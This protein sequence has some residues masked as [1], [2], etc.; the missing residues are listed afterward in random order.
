MDRKKLLKL[1]RQDE[2]GKLD[3]KE[4]LHLKTSSDKKEFVKDVCAL[5]NSSG[6]RAYLVIGIREDRKSV[7]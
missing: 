5:A 6:G 4:V 3:F 7:V 1:L 2:G